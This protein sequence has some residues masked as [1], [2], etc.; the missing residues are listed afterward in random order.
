MPLVTDECDW[1]AGLPGD[2]MAFHR[3]EDDIMTVGKRDL[4]ESTI[5]WL[6]A[7]GKPHTE[8]F[9]VYSHPP[10]YSVHRFSVCMMNC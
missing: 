1:T 8:S 6:M 7:D 4:D 10:C 2:W 3:Q 5:K 9:A